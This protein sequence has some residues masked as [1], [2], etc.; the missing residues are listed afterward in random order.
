MHGVSVMYVSPNRKG[1]FQESGC[2]V[3][4][5]P[6]TQIF[7]SAVSIWEMRLKC[8]VRHRSGVCK[9]RFSPKD[10]VD[11]LDNQEVTFLTIRLSG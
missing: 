8:G 10:V 2:Q 6:G 4:D 5:S 7:V 11:V 9:S 1:S 3:P